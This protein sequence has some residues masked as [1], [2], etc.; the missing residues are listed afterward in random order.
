ME[1]LTYEGRQVLTGA[2]AFPRGPSVQSLDFKVP[3]P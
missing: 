2:E 3:T 1:S